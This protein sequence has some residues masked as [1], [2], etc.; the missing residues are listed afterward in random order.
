M[1]ATASLTLI[2]R[3]SIPVGS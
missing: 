2:E 1:Q 3:S